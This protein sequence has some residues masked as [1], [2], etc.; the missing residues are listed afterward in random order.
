MIRYLDHT[1]E[2]AAL[3]ALFALI[4]TIDSILAM[5]G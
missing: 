5:V 1:S 4:C 2:T 3:C